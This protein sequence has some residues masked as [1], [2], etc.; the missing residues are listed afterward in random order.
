MRD[1]N[2]GYNVVAPNLTAGDM[3][4]AMFQAM[5]L[6]SVLAQE[7]VKPTR[8]VYSSGF[9]VDADEQDDLQW[10]VSSFIRRWRLTK[11]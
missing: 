6:D 10:R 4:K 8:V 5:R 9:L 7:V 2:Y 11:C 3:R 1:R